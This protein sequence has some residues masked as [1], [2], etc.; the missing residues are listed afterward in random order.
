MGKEPWPSAL[1]IWAMSRNRRETVAT[2]YGEVTKAA[3]VE[4]FLPAGSTDGIW[5]VQK[6]NWTGVGLVIPRSHFSDGRQR[7]ELDG[8]GVY[9]LQGPAE[10]D[11]FEHQ[12]YIGESDNLRKRL[13]D[14]AKKIDFWTRAVVFSAKDEGL[15]KAHVRQLESALIARALQVTRSAVVNSNAGAPVLLSEADEAMVT[16]FLDEMLTLYPLMGVLAFEDARVRSGE[17]K[18]LLYCSGPDA[19]AQGYEVAD[20]FLVLEGALLRRHQV[21]SVY[22]SVT[23]RLAA[24]WEEGLLEVISDEQWRLTRGHVFNSPSMAA[25]CVLGR[26][27]NGRTEWRT[28]EGTSLKELQDLG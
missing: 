9:V 19:E 8:P 21:P 22:P 1:R 2:Y 18:Q 6:S 10:S 12:V 4:I 11:A 25:A 26:S 16:G 24:L 20:G 27:A 17:T 13:D 23:K 28:I 5:K 14:H 7:A 3:S 15:N